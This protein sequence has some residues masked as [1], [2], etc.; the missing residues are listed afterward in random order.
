MIFD[1]K[2]TARGADSEDDT[3]GA[4]FKTQMLQ[5]F[6]DLGKHA[7]AIFAGLFCVRQRA[8]RSLGNSDGLAVSAGV[9]SYAISCVRPYAT[10]ATPCAATLTQGLC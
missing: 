7:T 3:L 10:Y 9:L 6:A 4:L 5:M 1:K 8:P 2:C